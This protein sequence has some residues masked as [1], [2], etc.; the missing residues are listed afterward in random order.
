MAQLGRKLVLEF[1][2]P[3]TLSSGAVAA[4]VARLDHEAAN[5]AVKEQ[6]LEK[7]ACGEA[8]KVLVGARSERGE[9]TNANVAGRGVENTERGRRTRR[10][11]GGGRGGGGEE[12]GVVGGQ[13][14][15]EVAR[16]ERGMLR[17]EGGRRAARKEEEAATGGGHGRGDEERVGGGRRGE[18]RLAQVELGG[19]AALKEGQRGE[20]LGLVGAQHAHETAGGGGED[21][22]AP[23]RGEEEERGGGVPEQVERVARRGETTKVRL[24][25]GQEL[26]MAGDAAACVERV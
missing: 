1:S 16:V 4:R 24:D 5:D 20:A 8:D 25:L 14:V 10:G 6:T 26:G 11:R 2:S 15:A 21:A 19:D 13:L 18:G 17:V 9:E 22:D 23:G 12:R 3:Q 7:A